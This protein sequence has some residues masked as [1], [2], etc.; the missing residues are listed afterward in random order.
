[1]HAV[2]EEGSS[3]TNR[4]GLPEHWRGIRGEDLSAIAKIPGCTFCHQSG[5][6]GG[7]E[8]FEGALKMA[9]AAL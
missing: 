9:I 8:T 3:F 4:V 7:N 1:V 5:F 2:S 6:I